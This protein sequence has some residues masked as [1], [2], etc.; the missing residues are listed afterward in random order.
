MN[1]LLSQAGP[2]AMRTLAL[3]E[4]DVRCSGLIRPAA[5]ATAFFRA[6]PAGPAEAKRR[7]R[8]AEAHPKGFK[9]S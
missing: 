9:E 2:I 7:A 8:F 6:G 4:V 5:G 3:R 1:F